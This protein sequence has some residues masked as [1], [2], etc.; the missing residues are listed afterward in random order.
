MDGMRNVGQQ[1]FVAVSRATVQQ[2]L[3][4]I[5]RS[6]TGAE[7]EDGAR[8]DELA[9]GQVV[10]GPELTESLDLRLELLDPRRTVDRLVVETPE[11]HVRCADVAG[12]VFELVER[13]DHLAVDREEITYSLQRTTYPLPSHYKTKLTRPEVDEAKAKAEANFHEAKANSHEAEL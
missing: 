7:H 3:H 6:R 4:S 1:L 13:A 10:V 8:H 9:R 5:A 2:H 12:A 11:R